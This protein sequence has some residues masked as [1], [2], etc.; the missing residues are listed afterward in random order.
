MKRLGREAR[1]LDWLHENDLVGEKLVMGT[2]YVD[3]VVTKVEYEPYIIQFTTDDG[4]PMDA[5]RTKGRYV[6]CYS[7]GSTS[8]PVNNYIEI[9]VF[10]K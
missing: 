4:R 7:N 1:T 5:K 6:R 2:G 10:G 8:E 9:E 3:A